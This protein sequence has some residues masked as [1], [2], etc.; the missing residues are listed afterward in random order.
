MRFSAF[1]LP[2][3]TATYADALAAIGLSR[4]LYLLSGRYAHISPTSAA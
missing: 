4:M 2:K 3:K 1:Y